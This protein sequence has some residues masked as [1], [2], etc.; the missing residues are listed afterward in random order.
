MLPERGK[1]GTA[2]SILQL[3]SQNEKKVFF[4]GRQGER[5]GFHRRRFLLH[6]FELLVRRLNA[7][8]SSERAEKKNG[9]NQEGEEKEDPP[10]RKR[11]K[12]NAERMRT[13]R[14]EEQ[15]ERVVV[16]TGPFDCLQ[17]R[18]SILGHSDPSPT[19]QLFSSLDEKQSILTDDV[20][21]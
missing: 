4:W 21:A 9:E 15:T 2:N 12:K 1:N 8:E 18:L 13:T 3:W 16:G 5:T 6:F 14:R 7:N 20:D 11:Q 17:S 19:S 10:D